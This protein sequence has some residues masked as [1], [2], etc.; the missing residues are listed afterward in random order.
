MT[1]RNRLCSCGCGQVLPNGML[2]QRRKRQQD[3]RKAK[4]DARRP[5]ASERGYN[6][7]WAKA[8]ATYLL[9]HPD[10]VKCGAP[11]NVV[12]HIR[13]HKGDQTLFWDKGN[14]QSLCTNHHASAKQIE[15]RRLSAA[16]EARVNPFLP[17]PR[18]PVTIVCGPAGAGKTTY[19]RRHA[20]EC[21]LVIDLDDIRARF[22]LGIAD[23]L[24][25]RNDILAGL[26]TD[27]RHDRA[28][29]I[30]SAPTRAERDAWEAK[31]N[32]TVVMLN[33]P[34]GECL[35][36][37]GGDSKRAEFARDWWSKYSADSGARGGG[38]RTS[39][40]EPQTGEPTVPRN[41]SMKI[42]ND[43]SQR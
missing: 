6:D 42:Q 37:I 7:R 22:G 40:T 17:K 30:V 36:R 28:F 38:L 19:A 21:D 9:S 41:F 8:R 2:C 12:D 14:W 29:F 5:N 33:T 26:A 1:A 39:P 20:T 32:G 16:A 3:V 25:A 34:L 10:C 24:E 18:I 27:T 35:R 11:A 4:A 43:R 23:A 13:P 31:L 15:E